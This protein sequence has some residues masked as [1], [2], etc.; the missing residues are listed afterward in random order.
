MML[1]VVMT[2]KVPLY[3]SHPRSQIISKLLEMKL[4]NKLREMNKNLLYLRNPHNSQGSESP[5]GSS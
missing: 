1:V 4:R 5:K 3:H 2:M